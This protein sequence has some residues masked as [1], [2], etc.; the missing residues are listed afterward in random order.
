MV[1]NLSYRWLIRVELFS[2]YKKT[3]QHQ[4]TDTSIFFFYGNEEG[5]WLISFL[6][7]FRKSPQ[8]LSYSLVSHSTL[9]KVK[10]CC[11][12]FVWCFSFIDQSF[13][14]C[15]YSHMQQ[16]CI[17]LLL[18]ATGL[19]EDDNTQK[20]GQIKPIEGGT[21]KCNEYDPWEV[22]SSYR[23]E[24]LVPETQPGQGASGKLA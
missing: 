18:D 11:R 14:M 20:R 8:S 22:G 7:I 24:A 4:R 17:K 21:Y 12:F 23:A 16:S 13:H 9:L 2:T 15:L 5:Q 3:S 6:K 1:S 19:Q 10:A